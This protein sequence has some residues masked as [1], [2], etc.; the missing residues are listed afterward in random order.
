MADS[1]GIALLAAGKGTRLKVDIAKP[2]LPML[3][4]VMMD[5]V[6]ESIE[7]FL[8]EFSLKGHIG[9]VVG[10]QKEKVEQALSKY[11]NVSTAWQKE[12]K[13]TAD[14]LK[15]YF[16]DTHEAWNKDYTLVICADTPLI[17][18]QLLIELYNRLKADS[19]MNA[20][21]AT[22]ETEDPTGYGRIV[23]ADK[24]FKIVEHKDADEKTR[25]IKEVNS[26]LYLI[27]TSYIKEHLDSIGS[28][29]ASNEF[30]LTDLFKEG[31]N[32]YPVL[33]KDAVAFSGVNTLVQWQEVQKELQQRKLE[34]LMLEGVFVHD[35]NSTYVDWSV[36]V[37]SGSEIYAGVSLLGST[38]I[39]DNVVIENNSFI[40][41][42]TVSSGAKILAMSHLEEAEVG[43]N[44]AIGPYARLRP[45][46]QIGEE[47][48]IGN[49]VEI[50]K[51]ILHKGVKVSHLSY[52]GD[53]EI[54]SESNIGCGFI[55]C[56]YDGANKHKTNIGSGT[57]IGSDVQAIAP[58][59]I[60]DKAFVAAGS[61][62]T[63]DVPDGG[64]AIARQKQATKPDMAKR[65]LKTKKDS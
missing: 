34:S 56:N 1:I 42:S 5:F 18:S 17:T 26:G 60:G 57:F 61:T 13:G 28:N 23:R 38:K 52:V 14:A 51:A 49:F 2:L 58:V 32:V 63:N 24:G 64:F 20:V 59:N 15:S 41:N 65:F 19:T 48:K 16:N 9:A 6:V 29:N 30:Y 22:F 25:E 37:G 43:S 21:C 36:Q 55:T 31:E 27:K 11:S 45:K 47:S 53:A 33:F 39:A 12:Q 62:I 3:G 54:G 10:H 44:A 35:L 4:Q 40:K 50:K 7:G 8:S 46:A